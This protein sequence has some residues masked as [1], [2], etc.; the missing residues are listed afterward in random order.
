MLCLYSECL[1]VIHFLR[2]G[3]IRYHKKPVNIDN[4]WWS[5]LVDNIFLPANGGGELNYFPRE[6]AGEVTDTN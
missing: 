2:V 6:P 4:G 3:S 1:D 5:K